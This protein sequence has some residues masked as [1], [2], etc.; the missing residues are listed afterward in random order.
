MAIILFGNKY[1]AW[2][3]KDVFFIVLK[4]VSAGMM[5][6]ILAYSFLSNRVNLFLQI[7]LVLLS[8]FLLLLIVR[9]FNKDDKE[10]FVKIFIKKNILQE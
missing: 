3:L 8:Y 7:F 5:S 10:L 9:T 1:S 2:N 6:F 4:P